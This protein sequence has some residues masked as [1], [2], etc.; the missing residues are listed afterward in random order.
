MP[1]GTSSRLGPDRVAKQVR[2]TH[3]AASPRGWDRRPR[4]A[5]ARKAGK[6]DGARGSFSSPDIQPTY[7]T[8]LAT[9]Q[10]RAMNLVCEATKERGMTIVIP[11]AMADSMNPV[12]L[13][14]LL[15]PQAFRVDNVV[16]STNAATVL[17]KQA[18][19]HSSCYGAA[20]R[21]ARSSPGVS[22]VARFVSRS[23][24]VARVSGY[25]CGGTPEG[26]L[27][28]SL[29][30]LGADYACQPRDGPLLVRCGVHSVLREQ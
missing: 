3:F 27:A 5:L 29:V 7:A 8:A 26:R 24:A 20:V 28:R 22:P 9:L 14:G 23:S 2:P 21:R 19:A 13:E 4:S 15:A 25:R 6:R 17:R 10:L 11:S 1:S 30:S 16:R 12:G 18:G